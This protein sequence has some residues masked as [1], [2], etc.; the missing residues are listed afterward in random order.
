M[1]ASPTL[2]AATPPLSGSYFE[3]H[4]IDTGIISPLHAWA[5]IYF[6]TDLLGLITCRD[7]VSWWTSCSLL[8]F[9][10]FRAA[11]QIT[12]GQENIYWTKVTGEA[13]ENVRRNQPG[14]GSSFTVTLCS[15]HTEPLATNEYRVI[16]LP[17]TFYPHQGLKCVLRKGKV[18]LS[19]VVFTQLQVTFL[20]EAHIPIP[21]FQLFADSPLRNC[22]PNPVSSS[23][24]VVRC[25]WSLGL[26]N[27]SSVGRA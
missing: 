20:S 5:S 15:R 27:C 22:T 4:V 11:I 1:N 18:S 10:L 19:C 3:W 7:A 23:G 13:E 17:N 26:V 2:S 24:P 9:N 6:M 8:S 14:L 16:L 12:E 21:L 25:E